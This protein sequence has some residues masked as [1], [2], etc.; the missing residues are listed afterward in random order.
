MTERTL[1]PTEALNCFLADVERR[2]FKMAQFAVMNSDDALDIVQD[3]MLVFVRSYAKQP[4]TEWGIL[5]H[6]TLHSRIIDWQ[7]RATVRNRFRAW[8]GRPY[9]D[10]D[11]EDPIQTVADINSPNAEDILIRG[12]I[13]ASLEKALSVLPSRQRQAFLLRAWEGM[14]VAQ[15]ASVMGCSQGSVKTHYSRAVHALRKLLEG[16]LP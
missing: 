5:F 1:E 8:F 10:E 3:A 14:D 6:R 2:A 4:A 12:D 16:Q 11:S 9:D 13:A 15:T 7:R